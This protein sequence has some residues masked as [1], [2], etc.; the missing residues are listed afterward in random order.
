MF[1]TPTFTLK[2]SMTITAT[3]TLLS[4]R[5]VS[6]TQAWVP[7]TLRSGCSAW[8]MT[9]KDG[10]RMTPSLILHM[11]FLRELCMTLTGA[12]GSLIRTDSWWPMWKQMKITEFISTMMTFTQISSL[13]NL[14]STLKSTG[15]L[16]LIKTFYLISGMT[17]QNYEQ[18]KSPSFATLGPKTN[19]TDPWQTGDSRL[20]TLTLR[21]HMTLGWIILC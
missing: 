13:L 7:L 6:N 1:G 20:C 18:D 2:T 3:Q 9:T 21:A 17:P 4:W 16:N 14:Q 10:T 11:D 5:W 12:T 15:L 8:L 19:F